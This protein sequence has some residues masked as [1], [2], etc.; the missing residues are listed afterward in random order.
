MK[1]ILIWLK[2]IFYSNKNYIL[3]EQWL[4]ELMLV[5]VGRSVLIGIDWHS[6]YKGVDLNA[7][8]CSHH[9]T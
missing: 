1:V 4:G 3:G 7:K 6:Y 8:C 2:F 5:S 9:M